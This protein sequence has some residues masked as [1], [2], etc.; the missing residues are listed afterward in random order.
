MCFKATLRFYSVSQIS[1]DIVRPRVKDCG[2]LELKSLGVF[3]EK[4]DLW[5]YHALTDSTSS[6][7]S[8]VVAVASTTSALVHILLHKLSGS[9]SLHMTIDIRQSV[10]VF[11]GFIYFRVL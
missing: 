1:E 9:F 11:V 4:P 2:M 6:E 7:L 5:A 3:M 10:C 8:G